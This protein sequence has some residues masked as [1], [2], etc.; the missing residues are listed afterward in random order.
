MAMIALLALVL[1]ALI[2]WPDAVYR[3]IGHPVTWL[4]RLISALDRG[5]NHG[6][7]RQAKGALTVVLVV[8][9][10]AIPAALVQV[11]LGPWIAAM[12]AWPLVAARSLD[13]HLR[14]VARPLAAGDLPA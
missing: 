9:A 1:D 13:Q 3:R 8:A 4:G 7:L 2:G 5:L 14:A 10:A 11:W 6:V 12:L